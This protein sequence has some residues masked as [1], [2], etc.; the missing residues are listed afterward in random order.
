MTP[1]SASRGSRHSRTLNP[2]A[3][4]QLAADA[5]A[6]GDELG[7]ATTPT[8]TPPAAS[9]S[10]GA[11]SGLLLGGLPDDDVAGGDRAGRIHR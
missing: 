11:W 5:V 3:L 6:A 9:S 10:R 8:S 2:L 1:I 7:L 4:L